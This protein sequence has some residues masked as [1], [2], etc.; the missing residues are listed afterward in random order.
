MQV[1][2]GYTQLR[3]VGTRFSGLC[4]FH[5]E[6]SGSF[7]VN[8]ADNLYYCFGCQ[9]KGDIITFVREK[10]GLDFVG[11]VEW[12]AQKSGITLRYTDAGEGRNRQ[13]KGSLQDLIAKAGEWYHD[14][15][16][17]SPDAAPA[18]AYL[19]KRGLDGDLV[20]Q[21]KIGWA[22][23]D[24]DQL[25]KHL[26]AP[27]KDFADSGLGMINRRNRQQDWFRG[28]ILFPI[29]DAQ[30]KSVGFGGRIMPGA[31]GAKYINSRDSV[32]YNKSSV[33]YG[34]DRAKSN[35]VNAGEVLICEGYTD[36]IGYHIAG[37]PR[38][39]ATCGT[40]LTEEHVKLLKKFGSRVVLSFDG[41]SAGQAAAEKFY[42][43]ER[44][45]DLDV[46]VVDLPAGADPGDLALS[47]PKRLAAAVAEARPFLE[48]RVNRVLGS[49]AIDSVEGR[50]RA[51]EDALSVLAEHPDPLVQDAYALQIADHTKMAH[52]TIR[53]M[54]R[55]AKPRSLA[56]KNDSRN[57]PGASGG[58]GPSGE[59]GQGN[60]QG[61]RNRRVQNQ[62]RGAMG[63]ASSGRGREGPAGPPA[64]ELEALRL[65]VH[66]TDEIAPYVVP[67]LFS[68]EHLGDVYALLLE[69]RDINKVIEL[70][71]GESSDILFRLSVESTD[72]GPLDVA[73]RLW[74]RFVEAE[75]D[76][77][78]RESS[79]SE[80]NDWGALAA[81]M[82]WFQAMKEGL[83]D[84]VAKEQTVMELLAW[85][86]STSEETGQPA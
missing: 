15:L 39:V 65:A 17:T 13:R 1:I 73:S 46:R 45:Y 31:E 2:S 76:N 55:T 3:R 8:A 74:S 10:E 54:L 9:A 62:P 38:A 66:R 35:I 64:T 70:V 5:S 41:D 28:R 79:A 20:R 47:D 53:S 44:K 51:A 69:H 67:D 56:E 71:D 81:E 57:R 63:T 49:A 6:K 18:R 59:A 36:V 60:Q 16:L 22:P 58:Y 34:L 68:E 7:S 61:S 14:R 40:A 33:L 75:K 23:D 78:M 85:M 86:M 32:I 42:A 84:P 72:A 30:G 27:D 77:R 29:S 12:L 52:D 11:A 19:R 25:A 43:W 26:R 80:A 83:R 4:P 48:F 24:W 21:F 50:A 82:R 37:V